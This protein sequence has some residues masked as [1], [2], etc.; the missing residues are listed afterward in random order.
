MGPSKYA[1]VVASIIVA[2]RS[3]G[4][5]KIPVLI[6]GNAT[7]FRLCLSAKISEFK[8][9]SLSFS[10]SCSSPC[11]GPTAW[12]TCFALRFPP[13]VMTAPPT[14]VPPILLH[15]SWIRGPPFRLI[16]PATPPPR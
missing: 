8:V 5:P 16:A 2:Q 4:N 11:R 13:V 14:W 12:I 6:A 9:A 1:I 10:S 3:F 15:S 7:L